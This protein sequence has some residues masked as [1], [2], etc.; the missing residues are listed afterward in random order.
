M[1]GDE[2]CSVWKEIGECDMLWGRIW[3]RPGVGRI[4]GA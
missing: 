4:W 1:S 2:G 3:E